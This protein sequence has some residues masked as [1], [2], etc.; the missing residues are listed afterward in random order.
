[1]SEEYLYYYHY[2]SI[3]DAK[4]IIM[5][6]EILPSDAAVGD[7]AYGDGGYLTTLRPD[8]GITTIVNNNWGGAARDKKVEAYFALL[9][10][11]S[12]VVRAEVQRDIQVH[13]G[14]LKLSAYKGVLKNS[15]IWTMAKIWKFFFFEP[16]P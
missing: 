5:K 6:G 1:M 15:E 10:P 2:T 7:A 8:L 12:K 3:E 11:A 16:F 9:M 14:C 13:K 4:E